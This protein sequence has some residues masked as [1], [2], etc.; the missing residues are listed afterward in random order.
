MA[1]IYIGKPPQTYKAL[2]RILG[3]AVGLI[4]EKSEIRQQAVI[5]DGQLGDYGIY[6]NCKLLFKSFGPAYFNWNNGLK[7]FN[8][9]GGKGPSFR[10]RVTGDGF[11]GNTNAKAKNDYATDIRFK[12]LQ[13]YIQELQPLQE[14]YDEVHLLGKVLRAF[15]DK[16][17]GDETQITG[18]HPLEV[19]MYVW[20]AIY[21]DWLNAARPPK[22][23][24]WYAEMFEE[25]LE[26]ERL[27]L[28]LY[29]CFRGASTTDEQLL[30]MVEQEC[31][32]QH[33]Y[34]DEPKVPA[35][36]EENGESMEVESEH[37][38]DAACADLH[39]VKSVSSEKFLNEKPE[40]KE[41]IP[42]LM[43]QRYEND[44]DLSSSSSSSKAADPV[45]CA[46]SSTQSAT[47]L[48]PFPAL[49]VHPELKVA[50]MKE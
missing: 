34:L 29:K 9:L 8:D 48:S 25:Y 19:S 20:A 18:R 7:N 14:G 13:F 23:S 39:Y 42:I 3:P 1:D 10:F 24:T 43:Q 26:N 46:S 50:E 15:R 35:E 47:T 16:P 45:P 44:I 41:I 40:L 33:P 4:K 12:P 28:V 37:V 49:Q 17:D 2:I 11:I 5:F 22:D 27:S 38:C 21:H 31:K 6:E 32:D 30:Q 36:P